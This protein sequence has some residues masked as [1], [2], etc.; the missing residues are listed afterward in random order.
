MP[1]VHIRQI[2]LVARASV[3]EHLLRVSGKSGVERSIGLLGPA[4]LWLFLPEF[5][6]LPSTADGGSS[7]KQ[8]VQEVQRLGFLTVLVLVMAP[9]LCRIPHRRHD[10]SRV[11]E[12]QVVQVANGARDGVVPVDDGRIPPIPV[13]G[14]ALHHIAD[15]VV[16][17]LPD[18]HVHRVLPSRRDQQPGRARERSLVLR[19]GR[20]VPPRPASV[21]LPGSEDDLGAVPPD[22]RADMPIAKLVGVPHLDPCHRGHAFQEAPG[23]FVQHAGVA[24][25]HKA[26]GGVPAKLSEALPQGIPGEVCVAEC[27]AVRREAREIGRGSA[28]GGFVERGA[29]MGGLVPGV[30]RLVVRSIGE[31]VVPVPHSGGF[32]PSMVGG[33]SRSGGG[34][35]ILLRIDP[36][37]G[38]FRREP[39]ASRIL[40]ARALRHWLANDHEDL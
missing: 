25:T 10:G 23:R 9:I 31:R 39:V 24:G 14:L 15:R 7:E 18:N 32:L 21:P 4:L 19:E 36:N 33:D 28:P 38:A 2:P 16:V 37:R 5:R 29:A 6:P 13:S 20:Q 12:R 11:H 17:R 30:E 26:H 34:G 8:P 22:Q 40:E 35:A 3:A 1:L 27:K